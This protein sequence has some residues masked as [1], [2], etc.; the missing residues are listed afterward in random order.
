MLNKLKKIIYEGYNKEIV[1]IRRD[2]TKILPKDKIITITGPRRSGKT[3]LMYQIMD[4]LIKKGYD[5]EQFLYINFEDERISDKKF[6]YDLIFQAFYELFPES[7]EKEII[8]FFDE[9]QLLENWERFVR[10]VYDS[11]TKKIYLTGSNSQMLSSDIATALRGRNYNIE[12]FPLSFNEF[13]RFKGVNNKNISSKEKAIIDNLFQEY[14]VYGGY[15]EIV[16][17]DNTLKIE[18][19]QNYFN[20]MIYRDIAERFEYSQLEQLKYILKKLISTVSSEFSINKLYNE[21][22]SQGAKLS[23]SI[24]YSLYDDISNIYLFKQIERFSFSLSER[25]SHNKK[26]YFYDTGILSAV[27]YSLSE[28]HGKLLENL[29]AIELLRRKY[30][31]FYGKNGKECDF[32]AKKRGE[33]LAVQVCYKLTEKNIKRETKGLESFD[34]DRKLIIYYYSDIKDPDNAM[35]ILDF[36]EDTI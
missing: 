25:R 13:K 1:F 8:L 23:K 20:V 10:R 6:D 4:D 14:L 18:I 31:I 2:I 28:D 16:N 36:L 34:A 5:R 32:I 30:E 27:N 7:A 9:I 26:V 17:Y 12:L 33:T 3:F 19:L 22:K 11:K 21:L 35:Q 15:P 24:L 29:V